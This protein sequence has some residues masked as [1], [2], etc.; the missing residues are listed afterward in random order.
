MNLRLR[1]IAIAAILPWVGFAEG[2]APALAAGSPNVLF[3]ICD[4]LNDTVEGMG[5]HPQARTPNIDRLMRSGVRFTNAHCADP[6]CGPSRAS[7]WTGLYP[8]T[9]GVYGHDQNNYT[10]R[11][12][13]VLKNAVT[14]FEHFEANGYETYA[15]G[16]IFH[17]NH[18]TVP[19]FRK[20]GRYDR[21]GVNASFGPYPWDG[22]ARYGF[23]V[24]HPSMKR[25][26]GINGFEVFVPLSDV[27]HVP[28]D[29]EQGTPGFDG[30]IDHGRPFR[31]EGPDDRALM[32]DERSAEWA[33]QRLA[34]THD[35]PFFITVGFMRPHCPWVVP[36]EYFDMFPLDE[37]QFPPYLEN[38]LEDC[39]R[40]IRQIK[41]KSSWYTRL[42]RLREA[43][44][45]QEGWKRWIRGYL[46]S[47]AFV[48]G[49]L[50]KVLDAVDE[51]D[52]A[53]NTIIVFTS[54][55]GFHMGEK[56]LLIKKTVWEESTRVP[57]IIHAPGV[58]QGGRESEHPVSLVDLYPTLVDLC[59]LPPDPNC[60]GNDR[61]LD[62]HSLR[63]LLLD[64]AK[65]AWDGPPV[66]LSVI[67][68]GQPVAI[69]EIPP[70]DRQH[71]TV[72]SQHWRYCLW[73]G[74]E[75]ELYDHRADPHEWHNLAGDRE[76]VKVKQ[77]LREE[78][79][80]LTGR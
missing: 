63:P 42:E 41:Q 12:S 29:S 40:F 77:E 50:G 20:R 59:G 54:D 1:S 51:S 70:V 64:P 26:W 25:P 35:K 31:Y 34:E 3:I 32:T 39:G 79:R 75:E 48:D 8:H 61:P 47:V 67:E 58:A 14:M 38:D 78:L 7:L 53:R 23:N 56:D 33:C 49:Q 69:G 68:G 71:F 24:P 22:K 9:T 19:L 21:F 72:R 37:I 16:K 2:T 17:N 18:H 74:G 76:H 62:G 65:G 43:Y 30:W 80:K 15:T 13:P 28:A 10:W 60:D 57:L 6:V 66:A 55:H 45:G 46:A 36:Q 52:Y 27:P 5:G 73:A 4:D 11:D 44:P